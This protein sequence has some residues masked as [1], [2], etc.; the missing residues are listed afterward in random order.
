MPALPPPPPP[1]PPPQ[2]PP[3]APPE[4][5]VYRSRKRLRDRFGP[6]AGNP[7]EALRKRRGKSPKPIMPGEKPA[8]PTWRRVV[9]GVALAGGAGDP[10][11]IAAVFI[12]PQTP[13]GGAQERKDAASPGGGGP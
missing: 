11:A 10:V 8:K 2:S 6:M 12:S 3:S 9:K 7:L 13:P 1:H 5:K 4:Y